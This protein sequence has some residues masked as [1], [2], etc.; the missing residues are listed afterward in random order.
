MSR[1][2]RLSALPCAALLTA[3]VLAACSSGDSFGDADAWIREA[4]GKS[5]DTTDE[6]EPDTDLVEFAGGA[7]ERLA[8]EAED[9]DLVQA[10]QFDED[11]SRELVNIGDGWESGDGSLVEWAVK[12]LDEDQWVAIYVHRAGAGSTDDDGSLLAPL[13]NEGLDVG[14]ND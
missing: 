5:A 4:C 11:P 12:E 14:N 8:C 9:G 7:Q 6:F 13:E 1:V 10:Y 3:G 2:S